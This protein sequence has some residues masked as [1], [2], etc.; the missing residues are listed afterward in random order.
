[1]HVIRVLV[2]FFLSLLLCACHPVHHLS[3][4]EEMA[5]KI[6]L[7][8]PSSRLSFIPYFQRANIPYPPKHLAILVFKDTMSMQIYARENAGWKFIRTFS[9]LAASG[10]AGP[11]LHEGDDQVPEG[12]YH[13]IGMN[14]ESHFLLSLQLNYPNDFDRFYAQVDNRA[15]LGGDIFIHGNKRSIGC[16]AIG[17]ENIEKLF[18][19]VYEVG[20]SNVKV[21]IAPN[22]FRI[23][24]PDYPAGMPSWTPILY[25]KLNEALSRFPSPSYAV[26]L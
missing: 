25:D 17:N 6:H 16:V 9:I 18:P 23:A 26:S 13:I 14:P 11:K 3:W 4:T 5:T 15:N 10:T 2:L 21:I 20:I 19:L 7:Y 24:S 8:G 12:I 22:D 1:M